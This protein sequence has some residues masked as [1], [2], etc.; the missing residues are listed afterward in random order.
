MLFVG[1]YEHSI[2]AKNRLAVPSDVRQRLDPERDGECLYAVIQEGPTLC[3][4]TERGFEQRSEELDRSE[5]PADELLLYEQVFYSLAQRL[6]IDSQ[7]R[8]RLPQRLLE[9][10]GL[11]RDVVVLGVKDHL[12]VHEREAWNRRM[13]RMLSERPDLLMSPRRAMRAD[14]G[15]NGSQQDHG[16]KEP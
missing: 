10:A 13:E 12:E 7:G 6:E 3:L 2:D 16:S 8:V 15:G 14:S 5:R 1:C 4:Y 9:L 11:G